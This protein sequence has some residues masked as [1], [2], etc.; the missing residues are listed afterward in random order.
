VFGRI[1]EPPGWVLDD[2]GDA[3]WAGEL[4][5]DRLAELRLRMRAI[6]SAVD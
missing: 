6:G 3:R 5:V 4:V 2:L 1:A